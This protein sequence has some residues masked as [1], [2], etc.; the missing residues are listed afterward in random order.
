MF[1]HSTYRHTQ[2]GPFCWLIAGISIPC[3]IS[4]A[5]LWNEP[6]A[7]AVVAF[8]GFSTLYLAGAFRHLTVSDDDDELLISFGPLPLLWRRIRYAK[9]RTAQV[10]RTTFLDG[11]GVHYSLRGG[12][13]W[14]I[15]GYDCVEI[16]LD[17]G[18]VFV[19]TDDAENFAEFL[20]TR[21]EKRNAPDRGEFP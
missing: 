8:A 16:Q 1:G 5:M 4:S 10:S 19:G 2:E 21:I 18:K 15:W 12:W 20:Q 3:F 11:W 17:K 14:N 9:M 13:V 6:V 7:S